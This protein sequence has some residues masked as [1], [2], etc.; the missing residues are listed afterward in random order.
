MVKHYLDE[1]ISELGELIA[2]TKQDIENIQKADHS[3]VDDHSKKKTELV[4][5][6]EK[7]KSQL[8]NE[9]V[10]L[11]QANAG[12]DLASILS[13]EIKDRLAQLRDSLETLQKFNKEYAKSVVVV[14]EFYDSLL[15]TMLGAQNP[16]S[17]G[18]GTKSSLADAEKLLKLR[19]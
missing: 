3:H 1:A 14:K 15:K 16:S 10:K 9:L 7:T 2:I 12:T 6:F 4:R 18:D 17:Y 13:D 8:D 11:A 19:I 5:K